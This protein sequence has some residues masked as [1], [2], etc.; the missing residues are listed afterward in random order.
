MKTTTYVLSAFMAFIIILYSCKKENNSTNDDETNLTISGELTSYSG[1]KIF[2]SGTIV[3]EIPDTLSCVNY[4]YNANSNTLAIT[5]INSGFNCCPGSL[6]CTI[7]SHTDTI[8]IEEFEKQPQ[9]N[10]NCLF[11]LDIEVKGVESK[12]YQILFIEPYAEGQAKLEFEADLKNS[13]VGS[14]CV[15]RYMYPWGLYY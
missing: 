7:N 3:S 4:S 15:T 8:I 9:C 6:Y 1:C 11:D 5:H 12:K 14:Y 2:K 10:C 13:P